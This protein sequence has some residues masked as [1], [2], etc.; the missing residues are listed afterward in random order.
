[1]IIDPEN[2]NNSNNNGLPNSDD[3]VDSSFMISFK[4]NE[5]SSVSDKIKESENASDPFEDEFENFDFDASK[6]AFKPLDKPVTAEASSPIAEPP[7][8]SEK[9]DFEQVAP[10]NDPAFT[11]AD[12]D[13]KE[14]TG[15]KEDPNVNKSLFETGQDLDFAGSSDSKSAFSNP[16]DDFALDEE[17]M[18]INPFKPK[19]ADRIPPVPSMPK[20]G[21]VPDPALKAQPKPEAPKAEEPKEAANIKTYG[22]VSSGVDAFKKPA[23]EDTPKEQPA[24]AAPAPAP[25]PFKEEAKAP[26]SPFAKPTPAPAAAQ[27]PVKKEEAAPEQSP[28]VMKQAEPVKRPTSNVAKVSAAPVKPAAAKPA[29]ESKPADPFVKPEPKAP[30]AEDAHSAPRANAAAH[31]TM[32]QQPLPEEKEAG[33]RPGTSHS[34]SSDHQKTSIAPVTQVKKSKKSKADKKVKE[35][36]RGGIFALIGVL[37]AIFVVLW[38]LDNYQTWF[39]KNDD[40]TRATQVTAVTTVTE[41]VV[42]TE[43][44]ESET[45]A[46]TEETQEIVATT[47]ATTETAAET[48]VETTEA[49]TESTTEQTTTTTT[50]EETTTTTTRSSSSN[51]PVSCSYTIRNPRVTSDGF[52]FDLAVTNN[53]DTVNMSRLNEFTISFN[54]SSTITNLTSDYFNFTSDGNNAFTATPRSGSLPAGETTEITITGTTES[55][56]QHFYI[57]TYH[58]DWD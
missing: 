52:V 36:G 4:A 21:K 53:G 42:E 30:K 56:V 25:S 48:T 28:F 18:A 19:N 15:V 22:K 33:S 12:L 38:V 11:D 46:V 3:Y 58:F 54:T 50:E 9:S 2:Q 6:S 45:A 34:G 39:G 17:A 51:T 16:D 44:V 37:A 24:K 41:E 40:T 27:T 49:T 29:A 35:P 32:R 10:A 8:A 57:N 5:S 43:A 23:K 14:F 13:F 1:M 47:E 31:S 55:H 7:K 26:V 20:A